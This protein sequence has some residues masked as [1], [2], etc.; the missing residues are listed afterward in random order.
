M[1]HVMVTDFVHD[2]LEP[3]RRILDGLAEVT[4]LHACNETQ[5][6]GRVERAHA[7]IVYHEIGIS[8]ATIARLEDCRLIVRAG[9][10]FDNIDGLFARQRGIPLV[11]VPDYGSEEVADTALAMLMGLTR[12]TQ[13]LNSRL[14]AGIRPWTYQHTVPLARLRGRVLGVV[15]LGR[16]GTA[17]ALRGKAL[18]MD[19]A[20][21]DPYKPDGYDRA[22]GIRRVET[23][24]ELL[25]QSLAVSLHCPL[26][27]ETR[28]LI[29]A[30]AM[31]RMP[32]G[33]Y[34]VN[35][36]RGAVVDTLA[37]PEALRSGQLAGA[38]ID[39]LEGEPPAE[40]HP[41]LV[42]WRNPDHPAYDR[43]ILNPHAAF[44]SEEGF[45]DMRVKAAEACR[46]ALS[47]KPLRN[48]VN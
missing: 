17:M 27:A 23:L 44:Y 42:A 18:G 11:N 16:I 19:V 43:L 13:L 7:L 30:Q 3:E 26:T 8:Q 48:V 39:V 15:G 41:L 20:F 25:A 28:H 21:Y 35:T 38:G 31:A 5:L 22:L 46:R 6:V 12:G 36:A 9:V 32:R 47:G 29:D 24:E 10:G 37:L 33:S 4:A 1:Y 45:L 2:T 34:L 14:R 40:D